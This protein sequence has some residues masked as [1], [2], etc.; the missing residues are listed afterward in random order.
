MKRER[1]LKEEHLFRF[2]RLRRVSHRGEILRVLKISSPLVA[3]QDYPHTPVTSGLHDPQVQYWE[4]A[5]WV[6]KPVAVLSKPPAYE[7]RFCWSESTVM[8][9]ITTAAI[10]VMIL[11]LTR[12]Q[13]ENHVLTASIEGTWTGTL[14]QLQVKPFGLPIPIKEDVPSFATVIEFK[15]D[16]RLLVRE[17]ARASEGTYEQ[18]GDKLKIETD[19]TIEDIELAGD[20]TIETL[21]ET[22]LVIFLK[23]KDQNIDVEGAP[24]FDGHIKI[25]L[26]FQRS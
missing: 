15:E 10:L 1:C 22:S 26:H 2:C 20:Y 12:C 16:G 18:T 4:P 13:E 17:N 8:T 11:L 3:A 5:K 24:A 9:P 14:A 25:T 7:F 19:Y 6:A 21:T 23:R